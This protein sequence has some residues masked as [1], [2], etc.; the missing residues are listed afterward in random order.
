MER[1][2]FLGAPEKHEV[3]AELTRAVLTAVLFAHFVASLIGF[4][5]LGR[6]EK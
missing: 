3:S 1:D 6:I 4:H 5:Y 2:D